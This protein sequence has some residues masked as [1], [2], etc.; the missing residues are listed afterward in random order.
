MRRKWNWPV[1]VGFI[2]TVGGLFSYEWFAQFPVTRD[3]PWANLL[4]FGMGVTLLLV[5]LF[6]AF[7]RPQ[8]YRG[9]IFG[10]IFTVI[11]VLL[12]AFFAYEIFY[13]LK[14]VP[15]SAQAPRVGQKAPEF[16]LPDQNGKQV[17]L[18]DLL[19][20]NG[21]ILIFYRGHW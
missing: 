17:G 3:F 6:R 2:V 10:S 4:L 19:S 5:G 9:K 15:L 13:V 20:P 21:A 7:G 8:I 18:A 12:F 1:W 14:Q 11:S 16:S